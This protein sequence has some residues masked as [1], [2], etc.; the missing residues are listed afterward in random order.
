MTPGDAFHELGLEDGAT[1]DAVR[2]A[3]L[4]GIK[5]RK[6]ESDPEGFRRLRAAYELLTGDGY[7]S[8]QPFSEATLETEPS[9]NDWTEPL[10]TLPADE[11]EE[12]ANRFEE[13]PGDVLDNPDE[14]DELIGQAEVLAARGQAAEAATCAR[15]AVAAAEHGL[16]TPQFNRR[17]IRLILRLQAAGALLEAEEIYDELEDFFDRAGG[18]ATLIS[19]STAVMWSLVNEI[20]RLSDDFPQ[21]MRAAFALAVEAE[22]LDTAL[23]ELARLSRLDRNTAEQAKAELRN[24]PLLASAYGSLFSELTVL[25][26]DRPP[27]RP[28]LARRSAK[29]LFADLL[30]VSGL[31]LGVAIASRLPAI[32]RAAD[33][34]P[35]PKPEITLPELR[36]QTEE[37]CARLKPG[38]EERC[39][40][41][42]EALDLL[43][44]RRCPEAHALIRRLHLSFF[45]ADDPQKLWEIADRLL[46]AET[47]CP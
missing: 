7:R 11:P 9:L 36:A 5:I 4:R 29:V 14:L 34:S 44:R 39:A 35:A 6:P 31:L 2:R 45:S 32:F 12:T 24:L 21:G 13:E 37:V 27:G 10:E 43:E 25:T 15:R 20:V 3:Y 41:T 28:R 1:P 19:Q 30:I 40:W 38:E 23:P 18:E 46:E 22:D 33:T 8:A 47:H 16:S 42:A 26:D 17:V